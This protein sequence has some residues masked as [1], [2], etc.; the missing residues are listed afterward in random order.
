MPTL[1]RFVRTILLVLLVGYGL[2]AAL[3]T[4][5]EPRTRPMREAIDSRIIRDAG[6]PAAPGG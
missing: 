4:L 5:V 6:R 1:T 2:V 3:A